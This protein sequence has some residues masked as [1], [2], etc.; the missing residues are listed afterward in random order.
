ML[1]QPE[2]FDTEL[3]RLAQTGDARAFAGLTEAH[4]ARLRRTA[5]ALC[6]DAHLAE[7]LVQEAWTEAWRCLARFDH[8]CRFSTWLH[9]ILVNRAHKAIRSA[10]SRP[11]LHEP[12]SAEAPVATDHFSPRTALVQEEAAE[13][14]RQ[15]V[16]SLPEEH[17]SVI[18]LRF[19]ADQPLDQIALA[20]EVPL[21]TVKSRLHHALEKLRAMKLPVNLFVPPR[22]S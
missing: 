16:A 20:L 10:A 22:E 5:V 21:G 11:R 13:L 7:D 19:F 17:R 3:V 12:S 2:P 8:R 14:M 1:P 15:V 9:A 18:E 6:R 4:E